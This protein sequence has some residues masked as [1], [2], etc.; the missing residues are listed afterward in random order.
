MLISCESAK[1]QAFL[2]AAN[3]HLTPEFTQWRD[4]VAKRGT[5]I[6]F[7]KSFDYLDILRG[8]AGR[9]KVAGNGKIK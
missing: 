8:K 6:G 3:P 9:I 4:F 7:T 1:D 2:Y 5:F